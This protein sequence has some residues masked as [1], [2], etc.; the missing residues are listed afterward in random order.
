MILA[1]AQRW[2]ST[3]Q[4]VVLGSLPSQHKERLG[5]GGDVRTARRER[6]REGGARE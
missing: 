2:V 3:G 6:G 4:K 5:H 1:A